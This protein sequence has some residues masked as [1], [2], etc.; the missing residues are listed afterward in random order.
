MKII[1]GLAVMERLYLDL[2][3]FRGF[4]SDWLLKNSY[5]SLLDVFRSKEHVR[6]LKDDVFMAD[7]VSVAMKECALALE[8][9]GEGNDN[10]PLLLKAQEEINS[11]HSRC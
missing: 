11:L 4:D 8:T 2:E 1:P 10:Y 3:S 6:T 7:F 5:S 9:V